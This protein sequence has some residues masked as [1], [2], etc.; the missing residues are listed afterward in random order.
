VGFVAAGVGT[1]EAGRAAAGDVKPSIGTGVET[2]GGLGGR[3]ASGSIG[4]RKAGTATGS[5]MT[6]GSAGAES[7][8]AME[9]GEG[10]A[11]G[12]KGTAKGAARLDGEAGYSGAAPA[13]MCIARVAAGARTGASRLRESGCAAAGWKP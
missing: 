11:T 6:S 7:K 8:A 12:W 4:G 10:T 1:C 13:Y 2:G 9:V 3:T 5:D